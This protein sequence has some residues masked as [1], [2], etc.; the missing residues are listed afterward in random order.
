LWRAY[1]QGLGESVAHSDRRQR[2]LEARSSLPPLARPC[3]SDGAVAVWVFVLRTDG[4][5]AQRLLGAWR[6]LARSE[7]KLTFGLGPV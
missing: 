1:S 5:S 6:Q 3:E 2:E 7:K 4:L